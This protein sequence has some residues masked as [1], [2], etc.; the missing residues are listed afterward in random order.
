LILSPFGTWTRPQ[1]KWMWRIRVWDK[2]LPWPTHIR[3][4]KKCSVIQDRERSG[5][6]I[7]TKKNWENIW[8]HY[9]SLE[10]M[11]RDISVR[12]SD[13]RT[14]WQWKMV[15][16]R[17][18]TA[19]SSNHPT[20]KMLKPQR[21]GDYCLAL[22]RSEAS[23][24]KSWPEIWTL[25]PQDFVLCPIEFLPW[26]HHLTLRVRTLLWSFRQIW[27]NSKYSATYHC[28]EKTKSCSQTL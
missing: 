2:F 5:N 28:E 20:M 6:R 10:I 23:I 11:L 3:F 8:R 18:C 7:W 27:C 21:S 22:G 12:S 17:R 24:V 1:W 25:S 26:N 13:S 4:S 19:A 14:A 16:Q 15:I 9:L